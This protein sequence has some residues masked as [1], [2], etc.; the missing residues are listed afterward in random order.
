MARQKNSPE[1]EPR[2][3]VRHEKQV[4]KTCE[5]QSCSNEFIGLSRQRFCSAKCRNLANYHRHRERY[6]ATK[7]AKYQAKKEKEIQSTYPSDYGSHAS[8]VDKEATKKLNEGIEFDDLKGTDSVVIDTDKR[9]YKTLKN[10]LD[11]GLAD[12]RRYS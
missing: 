5:E 7:A 9:S 10:R 12:P 1:V 8:M 3:I 2:V 4:K 6:S 11:T